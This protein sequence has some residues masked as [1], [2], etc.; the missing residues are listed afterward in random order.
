VEGQGA[1][2]ELRNRK[3]A[4]QEGLGIFTAEPLKRCCSTGFSYH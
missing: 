1:D 2:F 3:M 4:Q